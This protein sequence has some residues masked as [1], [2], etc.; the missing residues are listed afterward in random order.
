MTSH[1]AAPAGQVRPQRTGP[2][3]F[4]QRQLWALHQLA[5]MPAT[6]NLS[7][8]LAI[9][10][11]LDIEALAGA[12][13][14]L[15]DAHEPLRT[16]YPASRGRPTAQVNHAGLAITA[17][18]LTP[19]NVADMT[20]AALLAGRERARG[21]DLAREAPIR[22]CLLRLGEHRHVLLLTLH[23]IAADGWSLDLASRHLSRCY[24]AR[25]RHEPPTR[26]APPARPG[27]PGQPA[28][29][30][31]HAAWQGT[32]LASPA[33]EQEARWWID[34][35][36]GAT[37]APAMLATGRRDACAELR[38]QVVVLPDQLTA[39]L[40][41]LGRA[42]TASL[43]VLLLTA[44]NALIR[45]WSGCPDPV[46]GTLTASRPTPG[47]AY[48]SGAHYNVL[49]LRTEL[50]DDPS[51]AECLLRT[52]ASTVT[53]LDHQ[54]LPFAILSGRLERELGWDMT[55]V[56]GAMLMLD[57]YPLER[58]RLAGCRVTGLYLDEGTGATPLPGGGPTALI[59]AATSCDLTFF[60]REVGD[61]LTISALYPGSAAADDDVIA[62]MLGYIELLAAMC[63]SPELPLSALLIGELPPGKLPL[64]ELAPSGPPLATLGSDLATTATRDGSSPSPSPTL[65]EIT[66]LSPAEAV[67]PVGR[68]IAGTPGSA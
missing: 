63:E 27:P 10:G 66:Q 53:A 68:W 62:A 51:L 17:L 58:L 67:S 8:G 12:F 16:T 33:A 32:W 25:L 13:A 45:V 3:T 30:L 2:L 44:F 47:S 39:D 24:A 26:S 31:E 18:D 43:F 56:P 28:E 37:P 50:G 14:D 20:E 49:L 15:I 48:L 52:A 5:P 19:R 29:C 42:A 4:T 64:S 65:R 7:Y 23:H 46:T 59:Q 35:L 34:H 21:F 1:P 40:R 41:A 61:R 60:A 6:L 11:P 9:D 36:R 54:T 22:A 57:H 38:R 55:A